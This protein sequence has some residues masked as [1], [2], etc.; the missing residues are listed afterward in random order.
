MPW[1]RRWRGPL[2]DEANSWQ[3]LVASFRSPALPAMARFSCSHIPQAIS[4][5]GGRRPL[6]WQRLALLRDRER[7]VPLPEGHAPD[8][9]AHGQSRA[10]VATCL[11]AQ[12]CQPFCRWPPGSQ[13]HSTP[14]AHLRLMRTAG[15]GQRQEHVVGLRQIRF[16]RDQVWRHCRRLPRNLPLLDATPAT[17]QGTPSQPRLSPVE[18][19]PIIARPTLVPPSGFKSAR[20][21]PEGF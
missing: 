16:E 7:A 19:E 10:S 3:R 1:R 21:L 9:R 11:T 12:Q 4:G 2:S 17:S 8:I 5:P 15:T 14:Q 20:P 6:G 13:P 18:G